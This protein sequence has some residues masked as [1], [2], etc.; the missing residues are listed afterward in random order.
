MLIRLIVSIASMILME[1]SYLSVY[2]YTGKEL[3]GDFFLRL[4]IFFLDSGL[5]GFSFYFPLFCIGL[6]LIF[7]C[8]FN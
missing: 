5:G 2:I 1:Y 3:F 7:S 6:S 4:G 8:F